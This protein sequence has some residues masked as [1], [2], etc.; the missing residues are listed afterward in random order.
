MSLLAARLFTLEASPHRSSAAQP[1]YTSPAANTGSLHATPQWVIRP[2]Y[3][4]VP[5]EQYTH[6]RSLSLP[7]SLDT[8]IDGVSCKAQYLGHGK[9]KVAYLLATDM[10]HKF[11]GKVLKLC[12]VPDQVPQLFKELSES[13]L[14]PLIHSSNS[15][16]ECDSVGQPVGQWNAWV[17]DYATPLDQFLKQPGLP[18]G[19][20]HLCVVGAV[21]CMLRAASY[22]HYLSDNAMFNFGKQQDDKELFKVVIIDAG[23][24]P[25]IPNGMSKSE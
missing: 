23:S 24:R 14:Y 25:K 9:S 2:S 18:K 22:G 21:R 19:A 13:R 4:Q 10:P 16:I 1:A 11:T 8:T 15:C 3:H 12:K 20:K 17:S 5:V 6:L 7:M